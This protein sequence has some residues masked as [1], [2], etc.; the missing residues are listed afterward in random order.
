MRCDYA[1]MY[2]IIFDDSMDLLAVLI[3]TTYLSRLSHDHVMSFFH[4]HLGFCI[5]L[6]NFGTRAARLAVI[7]FVTS[8]FLASQYQ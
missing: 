7:I 6:L 5:Y 1:S 3:Q 2:V 8:P 4:F